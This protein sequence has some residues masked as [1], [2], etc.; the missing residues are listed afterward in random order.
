MNT[1]N[2]LLAVL[3]TAAATAQAQVTIISENFDT[4][5]SPGANFSKYV[6]GDTAAASSSDAIAA[7]V[8]I[9]GTGGWKIVNDA[10]SG[11]SGFSGIGAQYQNGGITGNT[12]ANLSDYTLSFDAK[13]NAGSLNIQIQT[14]TGAGF[15]G[16]MTGTLN[17]APTPPG[18]G[19]DQ[20]LTPNFSHYSL[21]LG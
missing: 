3:A 5:L 13:A 2:L 8:G 11:S 16:T 7:G 15:G 10:P 12:S 18:F 20:V 21:N 9:G 1:K 4:S 6:F 17:T 14:W 19:N